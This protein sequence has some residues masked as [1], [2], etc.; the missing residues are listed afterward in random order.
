MSGIVAFCDL[1]RGD[2]GAFDRAAQPPASAATSK[3]A[4]L[5]ETRQQTIPSKFPL[6]VP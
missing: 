2:R 1:G 4:D 6:K 5:G 3:N